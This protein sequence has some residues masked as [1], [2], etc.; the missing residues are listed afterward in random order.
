MDIWFYQLPTQLPPT[1]LSPPKRGFSLLVQVE[2]FFPSVIVRVSGAGSILHYCEMTGIISSEE[3]QEGLQ[4]VKQ[5]L[6][7]ATKV[8]HLGTFKNHE[9][10]IAKAV[11]KA[12][13]TAVLENRFFDWLEE[14]RNGKEK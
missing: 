7:Q 12:A 2:R 6:D 3:Y 13:E 11:R 9:F 4:K 14:Y 8:Y 5:V 10:D 1:P